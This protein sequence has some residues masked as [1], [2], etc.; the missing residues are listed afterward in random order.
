VR[1]PPAK[2]RLRVARGSLTVKGRVDGVRVALR[3][4]SRGSR[5]ARARYGEVRRLLGPSAIDALAR[6]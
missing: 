2:G 6:G 3:L 5:A 1:R 4:P